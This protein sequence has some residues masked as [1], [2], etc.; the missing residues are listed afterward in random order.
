MYES[1]GTVTIRIP[2]Q[3]NFSIEKKAFKGA[4]GVHEIHKG[5][6]RFKDFLEKPS[7]VLT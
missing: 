6:D 2:D 1:Q 3:I 4:V 5:K 7:I